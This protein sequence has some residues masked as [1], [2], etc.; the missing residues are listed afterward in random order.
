MNQ[1]LSSQFPFPFQD[2]TYRYSNNSRPLDPP[3]C[4]DMTQEYEGEIR[5]KRELLEKYPDRCFQ[6][7][8]HTLE[9]Q[10]EVL[11]M[12]VHEMAVIHP[13]SFSLLKNDDLWTFTNHRT[14][15]EHRFVFGDASTLP[16][17][18]LD[19][20]GRHIQ[21]D[22]VLVMQ[23]D[24][25]L[26]MDAGQLCFPANWSIKFDLGMSYTE[27]HS[28][29][30]V[31]SDSG[32]AA[33]VR[34]FLMRMEAGK[35]W[36]RYN[37]TMTVDGRYDTFPEN[38]DEWG[39]EREKVTAENAGETVYLRVED[40]RLFR[41]PRS[42]AILFSIHTHLISLE[43]LIQNEAW[44][45]RLQKVLMDLPNYIC[46]YKGFSGY[47]DEIIGYLKNKLPIRS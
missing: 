23:R 9:A 4:L 36:T 19:F 28:P 35:P 3:Y 7:F 12:L 13:S 27:F 40:Q 20:I 29:V 14:G 25:N 47:K 10:W 33:K 37:W 32:L 39:P 43:E 16:C 41:L 21:E 8:P 15:E 24:G 6:S 44:G 1:T 22:L 42:Q 2:D 26:Y 34:D 30:P 5:L 46:E 38:F 17:E 11:D 18:P 45:V 31:F